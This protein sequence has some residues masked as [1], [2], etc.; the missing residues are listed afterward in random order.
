VWSATTGKPLTPPLRH[1]KEVRH[2]AF[3]PDGRMV[4]T[5]GNDGVARVWETATGQPL[6]PPLRHSG[7]VPHAAFSPDGAWAVTT[8][9]DGAARLWDL[10]PD[11]RPLSDL[12]L[13]AQLLAGVQLDHEHS[14]VVLQAEQLDRMWTAL[15]A[16]ARQ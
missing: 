7:S 11:P 2:A 1:G 4:L 13:L 3:S 8:S 16:K 12:L 5:A 14:T 10:S 9:V 15:Q 6:T